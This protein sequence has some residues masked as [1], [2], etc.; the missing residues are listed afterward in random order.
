[1]VYSFIEYINLSAVLIYS[2]SLFMIY[3]YLDRKTNSKHKRRDL[4]KQRLQNILFKTNLGKKIDSL[5][6]DIDEVK[7][8]IIIPKN[9]NKY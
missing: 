8:K 4:I 9:Y 1:M 7:L 3:K 6:H 2:V 5:H